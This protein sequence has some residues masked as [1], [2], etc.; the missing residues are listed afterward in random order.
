MSKKDQ[1]SSDSENQIPKTKLALEKNIK[2]KRQRSRRLRT[3]KNKRIRKIT[4]TNWL[5]N[6]SIT[7]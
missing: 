6:A 4:K 2:K 1:I 7:I 3:F 5:A